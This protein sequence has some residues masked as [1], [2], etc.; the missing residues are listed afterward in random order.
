MPVTRD[1]SS[2]LV[3]G[4]LTRNVQH[5]FTLPSSTRIEVMNVGRGNLHVAIDL[6]EGQEVVPYSV[7]TQFIRAT[8]SAELLVTGTPRV[9]LAA[10][11]RQ[12][13]Y[14]VRRLA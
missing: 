6:P 12:L 10:E 14:Q 5:V 11:C 13:T 4:I 9:T 7:G 2:G 8:E 3:P 1:G